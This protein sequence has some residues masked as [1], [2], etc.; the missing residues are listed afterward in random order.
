METLSLKRDVL[1]YLK[2]PGEII[3]RLAARIMEPLGR[4][5]ALVWVRI[6]GVEE[7]RA[8]RRIFLF[9]AFGGRRYG[10]NSA[11]LF[12]HIVEHHP[13]IDPYWV[14]RKDAYQVHLKSNLIP[15]PEKIV[16]KDA[17]RSNVLALSQDRVSEKKGGSSIRFREG[18]FCIIRARR[19]VKRLFNGVQKRGF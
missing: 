17:F 8:G 14:M 16:F 10:D 15:F 18:A 4:F 6:R 1:K 11:A 7:I 3:P 19:V 9:G 5:S 12:E 13:E 2:N